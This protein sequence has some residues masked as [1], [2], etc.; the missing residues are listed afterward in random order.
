MAHRNA[1]L[2]PRGRRLLVRRVEEFGWPAARVAEAAGVSRATVY[3][4]TRRFRQEGLAGLQDRSSRPHRSPRA[5][6]E[7]QI[8]RILR[9]RRGLKRGPHRLVAV[10]G[11]PRST[12]YAV[13]RRH[14]C[15]R[16]RDFDRPSGQ[17]IRYVRARPG[18]LV[19]LDVKKLGVIPPGGG[20]RTMGRP[21][22]AR[23]KRAR[24]Y[25]YL[26]VAVDDCSRMAMVSVC[27]DQSGATSQDDGTQ[28]QRA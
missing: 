3:K 19:H 10:L 7:G 14:G 8:H 21:I 28:Q 4:W 5:L 27:P 23:R 6:S 2:T 22:A 17:P 12:I 26:H 9:L 18:E 13:L 15:S 16:L 24:G 1:P 11:H 20:H 25:D